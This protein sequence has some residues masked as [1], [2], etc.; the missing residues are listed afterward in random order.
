MVRVDSDSET[1][2]RA[3]VVEYQF[4][5]GPVCH[6]ESYCTP[7]TQTFFIALD[8]IRAKHCSNMLRCQFKKRQ[9]PV[10]GVR[11]STSCLQDSKG[12]VAHHRTDTYPPS[13]PFGDS[14]TCHSCER[15]L[16]K[17]AIDAAR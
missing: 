15:R 1:C 3:R 4:H 5:H 12:F 6:H 11:P 8:K 14:T 17:V 7:G 13:A 9:F 16:R 10:T 2:R